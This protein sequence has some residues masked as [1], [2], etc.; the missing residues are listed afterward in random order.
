MLKQK[1]IPTP[2]IQRS[3]VPLVK[4]MP[5]KRAGTFSTLHTV[6]QLITFGLSMS[7]ARRVQRAT[8]S[9]LAERTRM[10]LEGLGGLWV[11]AGQ[12]I[13]LRTD[14]L[15]VEMAEELSKLQYQ[16]FGFDIELSRQTIEQ[17]IGRS[18][19]D[20]FDI[21]EAHPFGAASISQVH[22]A[23]LRCEKVWVVI[24]VRRPG[25]QEIFERDFRLISFVLRLFGMMP[26]VSHMDFSV[27]LRELRQMMDEELDYRYEMG[28]LKRMRKKLLPHK[29]YVPKLF[30]NYSSQEV[31]TMEEIFGTL[32]SD[33][34][35]VERSDPER[36]RAWCREN[37]INP[38]KVGSRLLQS[39]YRQIF[40]DNIFHGDLHPGNIFL[41]TNS[42]FALIDMGTIGNLDTGFL[43]LYR[44]MGRTVATGDYSRSVDYYL[45]MCEEM[46]VI[47]IAALRAEMVEVYR[48][49][50][51]R[52]SRY[53]LPYRDKAISGTLALDLQ[54]VVQKYKVVPS[55]QM[56]RVSR[57]IATLDAN[58]ASLLQDA[59]PIKV[60]RRY[61]R[62]ASARALKKARKQ[63][64]PTISNVVGM[65]SE[66]VKYKSDVLRL[67]AIQFEGVQSTARRI[68]AMIFRA[69]NVI[70]FFGLIF[71]VYD[72]VHDYVSADFLA[73]F[74]DPWL[75][76]FSRLMDGVFPKGFPLEFGAAILVFMLAL[77]VVTRNIYKQFSKPLVRHPS[78]RMEM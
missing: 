19:E 47:D 11:K 72:F 7:W 55:W 73:R 20:V 40:E 62:K 2:L 28:N 29:V 33:Y 56:L 10:F 54:A 53:G 1:Q 26:A 9:E 22:R 39:F 34:L 24:K 42:R 61:Y 3:E 75:G 58:L 21:F 25:I 37:N 46:P 32:M 71:V 16:T 8:R 69:I 50:E 51:A 45:L 43:A 17:T 52:S 67:G 63:I 6:G 13:S 70:V 78:G 14:L 76:G 77:F 38:Y 60:I 57:A 36:V 15:T 12:F 48:H 5:V 18:I 27:M 64:G 65:F 30:V 41:L 49:W 68:I 74:F 59:D 4:I 23:H 66:M 44:D 31:I 35:R